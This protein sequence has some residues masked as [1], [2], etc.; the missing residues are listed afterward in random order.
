MATKIQQI[1]ESTPSG[2]VLFGSWLA[3]RGVSTKSQYAYTKS[4]WLT[5][6]AHGVYVVSGTAPTLFAAVA[7]YNAQLGKS[8]VV[9]AYTALELRGYSHYL[10]MGKPQA[11][12]FIRG[13]SRLPSWMLTREWDMTVKARTTS[14]LGD[15][16]FGIEMM[17][18]FGH[19]FPVS[20]PEQAILECLSLPDASSSLLDIYYIMESLTTLRPKLMQALLERCQ[21]H[22]VVRLFL[23]MAEKANHPW[24]RALD[25]SRLSIGTSRYMAVPTGKYISKYNM[26]IPRELAEYE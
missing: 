22:K 5:R 10:S 26:T 7:S 3:D 16:E 14:F 6:I 23:Y 19:T 12:L 15:Y 11:Y 24:Y 20:S 1:L 4:G 2:S 17:T 13:E 18:V 9:G 25:T 21:S 8:C